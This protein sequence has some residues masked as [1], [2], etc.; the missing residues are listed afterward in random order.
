VSNKITINGQEYTAKIGMYT[1][2]EFFEKKNLKLGA[3]MAGDFM[4]QLSMKDMFELI[5]TGIQISERR[6]GRECLLTVDAILE[7]AEDNPNFL[8]DSLQALSSNLPNAGDIE[9]LPVSDT[10]DSKKSKKDLEAEKK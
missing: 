10:A 1:L 7:Y 9:S 5:L 6:A 2:V 3:F 4:N 8:Q